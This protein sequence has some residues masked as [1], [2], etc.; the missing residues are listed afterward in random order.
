MTAPP[1][2]TT[3][4]TTGPPADLT[5]DPTTVW[6][7]DWPAGWQDLLTQRAQADAAIASRLDGA[8]AG[9]L[10][11][12]ATGAPQTGPGSLRAAGSRASSV[13]V[14]LY[15]PLV[16]ARRAGARPGG[17]PWAVAQLGQSLDGCIATATG[18][19]CFVTGP[20]SLDHLHRLRALC[21]AVLVG[22]G[23]VAMD[24]PQLTTRRVPGPSPVRVVLDPSARL[25]GQ[26]RVLREDAAPTLW[27]CDSRHAETARRRRT[28]S[29]AEVLAI[30]GLL[31]EARPGPALRLE[32]A[33]RAMAE[34]GLGVVLVEGG[35]VTV[36]R[37]LE[38]GL[39]DRLHLVVAPVIIGAGRRGLQFPGPSRMADCLRPASR[40]WSLGED[41]LWDVDLSAG[42]SSSAP[43]R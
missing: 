34:R 15:Q 25:D 14:E 20:Q 27:L 19:S 16:E 11:D 43:A 38:A 6:P 32:L 24:D 21:D 23:T 33:F 30:D 28:A 40:R 39:L 9:G 29:G 5:A 22:A 17:R 3:G 8:P 35:G 2:A 1:A 26:A 10:D 12:A 42:R 36:S 37:C 41:L 4:T 18:D 13:W 7:T 31:D